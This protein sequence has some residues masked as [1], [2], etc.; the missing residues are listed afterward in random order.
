[1]IGAKN[2]KNRIDFIF[3]LNLFRVGLILL[4]WFVCVFLHNIFY[5]LFEFGEWVFFILAIIIPI[6]FFI[7][8]F[9]SFMKWVE[10]GGIE[11]F[12]GK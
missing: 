3:R 9:Y 1:V 8:V 11:K 10:K 5:M 6:Y 2:K 12:I 7:S 4:G